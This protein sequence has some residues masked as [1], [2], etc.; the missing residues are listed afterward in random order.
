MCSRSW[1]ITAHTEGNTE[2]SSLLAQSKRDRSALQVIQGQL[3]ELTATVAAGGGGGG[4]GGGRRRNNSNTDTTTK[5]VYRKWNKYC[6]SCGVVLCGKS[7]CGVG[8]GADCWNKKEGHK[9]DAT[10]T[11]KM[12]GNDK[13]DH[14]WNLWCDPVTRKSV[15]VV[16][17]GAPKKE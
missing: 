9:P 11:N 12:G 3:R 8:S 16:P 13:R 17:A 7:G 14:L 2:Y 15:S 1:N 4:G 10:F 6:Y 5:S